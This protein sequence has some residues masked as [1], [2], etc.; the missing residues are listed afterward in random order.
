[1]ELQLER[2]WFTPSATIGHLSIDGRFECFTLE[3]RAHDGPK[4]AGQ[5][6]IPTGR[7]EVVLSVSDRVRRGTLWS[8]DPAFRLPLLVG[9]PEFEGIRIHSGNRAADT[10]GCI[11]VGTSRDTDM[12][13]GS[14]NALIAL[15]PKIRAGVE[16]GP[17]FITISRAFTP[18][19]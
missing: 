4:I 18:I 16:A 6:A 7:Y 3:D 14:R 19:G 5:T 2:R 10:E 15:F 8:P 17:L 11:L 1:M 12:I 13:G 9:V